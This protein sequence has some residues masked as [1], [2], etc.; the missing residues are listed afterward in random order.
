MNADQ[1]KADL[2]MSGL[3]GKLQLGI[4]MENNFRHFS[5]KNSIAHSTGPV[6]IPVVQL[7]TPVCTHTVHANLVPWI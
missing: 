1:C 4:T 2:A 7:E 6:Y 5:K 3:P